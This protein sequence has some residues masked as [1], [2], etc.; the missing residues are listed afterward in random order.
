MTDNAVAA[1]VAPSTPNVGGGALSP[2]SGGQSAEPVVEPD[3]P[4][5]E[6]DE[7]AAADVLMRVDSSQRYP[8]SPYVYGVN[9]WDG[10]TPTRVG[11]TRLGGNR[12]TAYN[13]ESNA[14][15]AGSDYNHQNDT[16]L[17]DNCPNCSS[18]CSSTPGEV[19]SASV[20]LAQAHGAAALVTIPILGYVA[21]D[22]SGPVATGTDYL[23]SRFLVSKARKAAPFSLTPDLGDGVVYQDELVNLLKTQ[24]GPEAGKSVF[25]SLDN[26]PCLWYT[27]HPRLRCPDSGGDCG[28]NPTTYVELT[29]KNVEYAAA[30]KDVLPDAKV[31]GPVLYGYS[32]FESLQG[33][34]DAASGPFLDYYLQRLAEADRAQGRRLVDVLDLHWYTE[35]P[36]NAADR[37][38]APR[39]LWDATYNENSWIANDA[40][41]GPIRLIARLREKIDRYYPGTQIAF[42]EYNYGGAND[43][44]GAVAQADILGVFG[45]EQVFAASLW[46]LSTSLPYIY[47]A[48]EM[49]LNYD[50][51]GSSFGDTSVA[52]ST[53]ETE[54][55]SVYASVDAQDARRMVLVAI[56]KGTVPRKA[57]VAVRHSRLFSRAEV[58]QLTSAS[59]QPARQAD[60]SV[61]GRNTL[62]VDLPPMSV[63]TLVLRP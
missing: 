1:A 33:A 19:T 35:A 11:L 54:G 28:S 34:P 31:F 40:L 55:T 56:N 12:L 22:I 29:Q 8:I 14:S 10:K 48:F 18:Q 44:Y 52:A 49:F 43:I 61:A 45:R 53:T 32:A 20:S 16:Y 15:N 51:Q 62:S 23:S 2:G 60:V 9:A 13:W 21:A 26:E 30:I 46:P 3:E 59:V 25:F 24:F 58:Y 50:N 7:P 27:T 37:V 4:V 63:T 41:H 42:T 5:I 17:C 57:G 6:P 47:A 38:Q 36:D 39:S